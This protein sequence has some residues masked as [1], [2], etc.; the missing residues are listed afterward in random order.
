MERNCVR[1]VHGAFK[2]KEIRWA[3]RIQN[4]VSCK[5]GDGQGLTGDAEIARAGV[6]VYHEAALGIA[7]SVV[8]Q[9]CLVE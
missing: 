8:G 4:E 7:A 9:E 1:K 2:R 3:V 6:T 5:L